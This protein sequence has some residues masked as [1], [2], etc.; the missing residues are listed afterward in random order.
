MANV[1]PQ[2]IKELR[3]K[4]GAGMMDSKRALE[5]TGGDLGKAEDWL[6]QQGTIKAASR[7]GRTAAEGGIAT[8]VHK[9]TAEGSQ[10]AGSV[11][12]LVELNSESDFVARTDT[13]QDLARELALQ[14]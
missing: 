3:T 9:A 11:G 7:A 2:L 10:W 13:F 4:T 6:R 8:Y 14:V 12:V 1:T 5:E